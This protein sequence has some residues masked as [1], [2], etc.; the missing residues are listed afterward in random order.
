MSDAKPG[1]VLR[2]AVVYNPPKVSD[3]FRELVTE[4]TSAAGWPEPHWFETSVEDPGR[5]MTQQALQSGVDLVIGAGGD[6]TVRV[7]ADS[8]AGSGVTMAVVPAGTGNLLARNLE[9]PLQEAGALDVAIAGRTREIDLVELTVDGGRPEH[10]AV[11]AGVGV[12]AL[13]MDEV[14]PNL[15][16]KVGPAAYFLAAGKALNQLPIAMEI[17]VDGGR[18][19]RRRA[20][21]CVVGNVG[22]LP[23]GL[24]L[25]PLAQ[26][27]D[28]RLDVW[29]ASPHRFR[30]W[31]KLAVR[32]VTRRG[33]REDPVDSW[34]GRRV[35]VQLREPES[36]QLDGDVAGEGRRLRA[37]GKPR[38]LRVCIP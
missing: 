20:M 13:I 18:R 6:G 2:C 10:F 22:K 5:G 35:V 33:R 12:D 34:Q 28:G 14:D 36:Y 7:V 17:S 29:V 1:R 25:M 27:D 24:V 23:G 32:L 19:R 9:L 11:M 8:M 26:F 38:A 30:H 15:K 3:D 31:W 16:K 21:T 4:R 37:Q